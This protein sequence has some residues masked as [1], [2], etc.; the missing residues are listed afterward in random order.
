MPGSWDIDE[1]APPEAPP[2]ESLAAE[3]AGELT[4][5]DVAAAASGVTLPDD[6]EGELP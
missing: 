2:D 1:G 4:E 6:A 3:P 5:D